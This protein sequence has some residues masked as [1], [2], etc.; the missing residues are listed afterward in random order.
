[1]RSDNLIRSGGGHQLSMNNGKKRNPLS[2]PS[3]SSSS[4]HSFLDDEFDMDI[5]PMDNDDDDD[6]RENL[7]MEDELSCASSSFFPSTTI[8]NETLFCS[9]PSPSSSGQATMIPANHHAH[10]HGSPVN[11]NFIGTGSP[12]APQLMPSPASRPP[13]SIETPSPQNQQYFQ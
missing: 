3:S 6:D 12:A 11:S 10:H 8:P 4:P 7:A 13:H 2:S 9:N 5:E 1:M